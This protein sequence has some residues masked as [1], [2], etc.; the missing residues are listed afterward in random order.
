M[1]ELIVSAQ[2]ISRNFR[3]ISLESALDEL[4]KLQK[5]SQIILS[6]GWD[7]PHTLDHCA[8]SIE[9]AMHGFPEEKNIVFQTLIGTT[10]FHLFNTMGKMSHNLTEEIPGDKYEPPLPTLET[11]MERLKKSIHTFL[12]H[13][14]ELHPHFAYGNLSKSQFDRA[15]AMHI[16]NHFD[17]MEY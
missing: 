1:P 13:E 16:A 15:N 17:A 12:A 11:A 10:A 7:L 6:P 8:R 2:P 5:A 3:L 9:H 4:E 14:H